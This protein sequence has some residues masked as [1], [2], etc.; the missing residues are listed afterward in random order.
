MTWTLSGPGRKAAPAGA[1]LVVGGGLLGL[2]AARALQ[3]LGLAPHVVELAPWLM[4][5][6]VDEGGG[7]LLRGLI[8]GL[9]VTV[10]LGTSVTAVRP[11]GRRL[12]GRRS[13][14]L[15]VAL[16]D[17]TRLDVRVV[18][19]A[20]GVRPRDQLARAAG[21][22]TG[23][24]G[25]IVVDDGCQTA[26][27]AV[28]AIGDC[29]C[30]GGRVYGLVTPGYAMA[31]VLASRLTGGTASVTG[32]LDTSTT[33]KLP[34]V[35]VASFGDAL[36]MADGAL[37]VTLN[38]PVAGSYSKLVVSDDARTLLGGVL[39]GNAGAYPLLRS[40]VGRPLPGDPVAMLA[41][42]PGPRP[43]RA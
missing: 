15:A 19:F 2:E 40:L 33:L 18:V 39:V 32:T 29:A 30:L 17:G 3:L 37:A 41:P 6:Q 12:R 14:P 34:G 10:H 16:T 43:V 24:R 7:A 28:H 38:N 13:G 27:P 21:L 22:A 20:A 1:G 23:E 8:E 36:G 25:G 26:D 5:Q 4:P 35:D 11:G 42:P 31:G 9:G